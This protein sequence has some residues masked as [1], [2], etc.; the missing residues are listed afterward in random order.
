MQIEHFRDV[1]DHHTS[2]ASLLTRQVSWELPGKPQLLCHC[3]C[4]LFAPL[5]A[6]SFY[7]HGND[8]QQRNVKYVLSPLGIPHSVVL[9]HTCFWT[10]INQPKPDPTPHSL[11]TEA[12]PYL[13]PHPASRPASR[14]DSCFKQSPAP[15]LPLHLLSTLSNPATKLQG[16]LVTPRSPAGHLGQE[17]S[18][19]GIFFAIPLMGAALTQANHLLTLFVRRGWWGLKEIQKFCPGPRRAPYRSGGQR[20]GTRSQSGISRG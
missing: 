5:Q 17:S 1:H 19:Q 4:L 13:T 11:L 14:A 3:H 2:P 7:G 16:V 6:P 10:Y 20:R 15:S 18:S 9:L 8:F 12:C